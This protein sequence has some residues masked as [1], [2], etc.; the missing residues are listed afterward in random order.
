MVGYERKFWF[1]VL[2]IVI[3]ISGC[4]GGGESAEAGIGHCETNRDEFKCVGSYLNGEITLSLSPTITGAYLGGA[5]LSTCEITGSLWSCSGRADCE[6]ISSQ[7]PFKV[8]CP[9]SSGAYAV[10]F[11]LVKTIE[12][13]QE[14]TEPFVGNCES[15]PEGKF[16]CELIVEPKYYFKV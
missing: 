15:T 4:V 2:L 16:N 3:A 14:L 10:V 7:N 5:Y 8:K 12:Q 1:F 9:A 11:K 13:G 6:I